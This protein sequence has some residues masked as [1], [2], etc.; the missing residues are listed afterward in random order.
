MSGRT[1]PSSHGAISTLA[2]IERWTGCR[3]TVAL[4]DAGRRPRPRPTR[5]RG[6]RSGQTHGNRCATVPAWAMLPTIRGECHVSCQQHHRGSA[7]PPSPSTA[8][9]CGRRSSCRPSRRRASW[10]VTTAWP[11]GSS[12]A[13][14]MEVPDIG[15]WVKPQ[16]LLLTTGYPLRDVPG[17]LASLVTELDAAGVSALGVKLRRYLDELPDD[18]L[19]EADRLGFPV[20]LLADDAAFDD[21]LNAVAD[22]CHAP[23]VDTSSSGPT[24]STPAW[25]PSSCTAAGWTS[26]PRRSTPRS[27]ATSPSRPPTAGCSRRSATTTSC[28]SLDDLFVESGRFR[29]ERF[30]PGNHQAGDV[31]DGGGAG[32]RR[33]GRP[34]TA[35]CSSA[36]TV[37]SRTVTSPCSSGRRPSSRSRSRSP[38]PCRPWRRSTAA[39][40]SVTS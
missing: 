23:T 6:D 40:S 27:R 12:R 3:V 5:P 10:P 29:S 31:F 2:D 9:R 28:S 16:E 32:A 34:R 8:S 11:A 21:L 13:N 36:T 35:W 1:G 20:L 37:P 26:S 17:G 19:R 7:P 14:V 25:S 24:P 39:T 18:M 22:R 4:L 33:Q 15:A 30:A 38:W